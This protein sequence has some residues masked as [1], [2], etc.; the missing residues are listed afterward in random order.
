VDYLLHR[1]PQPFDILGQ[2]SCGKIKT[3]LGNYIT[4]IGGLEEIFLKTLSGIVFVI[5]TRVNIFNNNNTILLI[6]PQAQCL[7]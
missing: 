3:S 7:Q 6:K 1:L 5:C 4:I 2:D